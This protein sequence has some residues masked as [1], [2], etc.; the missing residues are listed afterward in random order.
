MNH[1]SN[2]RR[3]HP[4]KS[5]GKAHEST[6]L[7]ENDQSVRPSRQGRENKNSQSIIQSRGSCSTGVRVK[8]EDYGQHVQGVVKRYHR[9]SVEGVTGD[10]VLSHWVCM[11]DSNLS[12]NISKTS[13][14]TIAC[15]CVF[16][17]NNNDTSSEC[18]NKLL[19]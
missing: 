19:F 11:F 4:R 3:Q 5:Q 18:C 14:K 6:N 10:S 16:D 17:L 9:L 15:I 7:S 13:H 12:H 1:Q 2:L 8:L